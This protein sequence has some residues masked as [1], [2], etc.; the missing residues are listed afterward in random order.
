MRSDQ[1]LTMPCLYESNAI[2][3]IDAVHG[4]MITGGAGTHSYLEDFTVMFGGF[5]ILLFIAVKLYPKLA[6]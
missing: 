4:L 1:L 3:P 5:L 6:E 2:Y